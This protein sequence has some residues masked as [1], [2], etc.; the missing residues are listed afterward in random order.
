MVYQ[1]PSDSQINQGL[2][3][4]NESEAVR[5]RRRLH[6]E[7]LFHVFWIVLLKKH[8]KKNIHVYM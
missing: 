2:V 8:F 3:P 6:V 5:D 4:S 1:H 7:L